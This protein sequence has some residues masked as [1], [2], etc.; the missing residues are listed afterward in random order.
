MRPGVAA[1]VSFGALLFAGLAQLFLPFPLRRR[2]GFL[3]ADFFLPRL[4][5]P[6]Q[7]FGFLPLY[8]PAQPFAA[9]S[10]SPLLLLP[11]LSLSGLPL[12][13]LPFPA[14][15]FLPFALLLLPVCVPPLA[16]GTFVRRGGCAR[17]FP[18]SG[19]GVEKTDQDDIGFIELLE[20]TARARAGIE[21]RVQ[22]ECLGSIGVLDFVQAC[23]LGH[24]EDAVTFRKAGS[25][26][27]HAE[28]SPV[29]A[30]ASG[31]GGSS[32]S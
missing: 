5:L 15:L 19:T 12:G 10:L 6:G 9:F 31:A 22:R 3:L 24:A 11:R 30:G 23:A 26:G 1:A 32:S 27:F 8:F 2:A 14:F 4:L 20:L 29:Y 16:A 13:F 25:G 7:T 18:A 17:G 28:Y 21:I